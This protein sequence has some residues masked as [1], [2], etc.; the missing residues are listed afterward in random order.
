MTMIKDPIETILE[1]RSL[2]GSGFNLGFGPIRC[3]PHSYFA[4]KKLKASRNGLF[5]QIPKLSHVSAFTVVCGYAWSCMVKARARSGEDVGEKESKHL[6]SS[7]DYRTLLDPPIPETY[8]CNCQWH[9][10]FQCHL[11][12]QAQYLV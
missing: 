2:K 1:K 8:F 6:A 12:V 11:E 10:Y 7:A 9:D 3:K 4:E 5:P